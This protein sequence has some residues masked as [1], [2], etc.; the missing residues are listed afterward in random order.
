MRRT[1]SFEHTKP[2]EITNGIAL[3][4][5]RIFIPIRNIF[6]FFVV[7]GWGSDKRKKLFSS[8]VLSSFLSRLDGIIL[9]SV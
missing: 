2:G 5:F 7:G 1:Y 3:F 6:F 9:S 4:Q 8:G